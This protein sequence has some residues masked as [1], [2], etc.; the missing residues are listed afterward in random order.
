MTIVAPQPAPELAPLPR[1]E[2]LGFDP[3]HLTAEA[4]SRVLRTCEA[5]SETHMILLR[6]QQRRRAMHGRIA[7][8]HFDLESEEL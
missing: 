3:R 8:R 6:E 7:R 5:G 4:L 2:R 1:G